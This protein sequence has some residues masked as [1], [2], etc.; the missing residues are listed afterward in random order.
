MSGTS[1]PGIFVT[2]GRYI[3]ESNG[4]LDKNATLRQLNR[5]ARGRRE[6][7]GQEISEGE[8]EGEGREKVRAEEK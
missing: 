6:R 5:D 2:L 7:S 3:P 1:R 4:L 8:R